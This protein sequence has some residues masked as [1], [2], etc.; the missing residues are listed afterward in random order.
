M[1]RDIFIGLGASCL[2][3]ATVWF[4]GSRHN[5][6]PPIVKVVEEK[7]VQIVMPKIEPDKPEPMENDP[8]PNPAPD[9]APPSL[10]DA[11]Q[12]VQ[13][14]SFVE[15]M[16]P[17]PPEGLTPTTVITIP[18]KV[19]GGGGGSSSI[20]KLADL[21]HQ[22]DPRYQAKPVYPFEMRHA[23]ITGEVIVGFVVDAAG[24]VQS[25]YAVSSTQREFESAAV[26]AVSKWKFKPGR[27]DGRAVSTR[28]QVPVVFSISD[29]QE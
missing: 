6:P 8:A 19:G 26:Q 20:F 3:H 12:I 1:R 23:G 5:P 27:K 16:R 18:T 9:L 7:L 28:M 21:D 15:P 24:N 4:V 10:P 29:E 11:A 14:D 13:P 2:V 22:P 17:P 25:A